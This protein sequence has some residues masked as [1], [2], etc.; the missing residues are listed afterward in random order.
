M[1]I[2]ETLRFSWAHIIAFVALIFISY[3]S[4]MGITYLTDGDFLYAG[5]GV[6][7]INLLLVIFFILPQILKGTDEKFRRKIIFERL[8]FFCAPVV[9]AGIMIP[10]AHFWNVFDNRS[11]VE[12]TFSESVKTTKGMFESYETYANSRIEDYDMRLARKK[13]KPITRG[14]KVDALTLQLIDENYISL[15]NSA[16]EWID[17]ASG[18]TVWNVFMTGNIKK[19]ENALDQWNSSLTEF[20]SR[21]M[22]DEGSEVQPFSSSDKSVGLAKENLS[23]LKNVYTERSAPTIIAI[24]TA[25]LLYVLLLFPYIIQSRN[26]KSTYRLIGSEKNDTYALGKH[27]KKTK[28]KAGHRD[29]GQEINIGDDDVSSGSN[30]YR[31]FTM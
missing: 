5:V 18:A 23:S 16:F 8:L 11:Q 29:D 9:F 6:L 1:A 27:R 15:K 20:S 19:I 10:Y 21:K 26:T 28:E 22:A 24:S 14:N 31:S 7:G 2:N 3:V 30:D 4:F 13:T 25:I 17:N 12:T